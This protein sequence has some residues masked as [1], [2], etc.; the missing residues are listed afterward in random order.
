VA[1]S[2]KFV[3]WLVASAWFGNGHAKVKPLY[4]LGDLCILYEKCT[5]RK[6]CFLLF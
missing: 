3:S 1:V 4:A 5:S 2:S 6:R